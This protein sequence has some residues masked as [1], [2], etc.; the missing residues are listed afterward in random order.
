MPK[1][2][3]GKETACPPKRFPDRR[4]AF[5]EGGWRRK[6]RFL[7]IFDHQRSAGLCPVRVGPAAGHR[8]RPNPTVSDQIRAAFYWSAGRV[9]RVR[10]VR[11][12]Q[13]QSNPVKP[14]PA[15]LPPP[16]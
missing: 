13:A 11:L 5:D 14:N 15:T 10:P 12:S 6:I 1:V 7:A 4:S 16:G 3:A 2:I 9:Q 8:I